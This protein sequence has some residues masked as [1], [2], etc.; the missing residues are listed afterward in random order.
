MS[1]DDMRW[2]GELLR[3]APGQVIRYAAALI[4]D[5]GFLPALNTGVE[6]VSPW[7]YMMGD[8]FL[9]AVPGMGVGAAFLLGSFDD[10]VQR[11]A[12]RRASRRYLLKFIQLIGVAITG[13]ASIVGILLIVAIM[14]YLPAAAIHGGG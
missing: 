5:I 10:R 4:G 3:M 12:Q 13:Y 8:F 7:L 1:I 9:Y 14:L 2:P 11:W 6:T